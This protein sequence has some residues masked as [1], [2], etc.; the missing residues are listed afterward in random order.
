LKVL[1]TGVAGLIGS[2][3]ADIILESDIEELVG[4]DN[5]SFGNKNNL[6][7]A[8][9][10]SSFTFIQDDINKKSFK[11]KKFD[12]IFHLASLKKA[13]DGSLNSSQIMFENFLMTKNVLELA[14]EK[15]AFLVFTSTSDIYGNSKTFSEDEEIRFTSSDIERYSY[16]LSKFHSE[17]LI[18]NFAREHGLDIVI[19]RIFGCASNRS[20]LKWSGGHIG[21]FC[22]QAKYNKDIII[23]GDGLQTRSISHAL[24]I[25]KGLFDM[26]KNKQNVLNQIINIGTNEEISILETANYI[27]RQFDS[28]SKIVHKPFDEMFGRYP[29]IRRRFANTEKAKKLIN[30]KVNYS[31]KYVFDEIIDHVKS[32][33]L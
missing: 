17:Q 3:L 5:L 30:Y 22:N 20:N 16:A 10:N 32:K 13:W 2:H 29:Q 28:K 31:S 9:K 26:I 24:D 15:D 25:S 4:I 6:K 14:K 19:P 11:G 27:I 33:A 7:K 23:H 21:L 18:F 1:I 12:V 8:F